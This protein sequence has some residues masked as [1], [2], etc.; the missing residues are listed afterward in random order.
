MPMSQIKSKKTMREEIEEILGEW[1]VM[2]ASWGNR[3]LENDN[4]V[5]ACAKELFSLFEKEK[6]RLKSQFLEMI[7]EIKLVNPEDKEKNENHWWGYE[8]A[9]KDFEQLR[10]ELRK[11]LEEI[12]F[13]RIFNKKLW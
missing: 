4:P 7:G 12:E 6:K 5:G 3:I 2:G 13:R 11:K 9:I 1:N 8:R 10:A